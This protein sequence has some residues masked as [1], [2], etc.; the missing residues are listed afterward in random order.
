[1]AMRPHVPL[2]ERRSYGFFQAGE[3]GLHGQ[4][5]VQIFALDL[6]DVSL[7]V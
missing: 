7:G 1:M 6:L 3:S 5:R 2:F 4:K